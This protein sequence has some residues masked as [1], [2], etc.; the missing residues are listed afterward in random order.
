MSEA[1]M[2]INNKLNAQSSS[3]IPSGMSLGGLP[4]KAG[5]MDDSPTGEGDEPSLVYRAFNVGGSSAALLRTVAS[6]SLKEC[7][8]SSVNCSTI[9]VAGNKPATP[10][11]VSIRYSDIERP[12][13]F[14]HVLLPLADGEVLNAVNGFLSAAGISS[15]ARPQHSN[16]YRCHTVVDCAIVRFDIRLVPVRDTQGVYVEFKRTLGAAESFSKLYKQFKSSACSY[17]GPCSPASPPSLAVEQEQD[18]VDEAEIARA[19]GAM[20]LWIERDPVEAL[21]CVGQFYM[22]RNRHVV[23]SREILSAICRVIEGLQDLSDQCSVM[24]SSVA[25]ACVRQFMVSAREMHSPNDLSVEQVTMAAPGVSRAAMSSDLTARREAVGLLLDLNPRFS[26]DI[27]AR[28]AQIQGFS[29]EDAVW[30]VPSSAMTV[31]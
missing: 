16:L 18:D 13:S 17:S 2:S 3:F 9:S 1:L 10:P 22:A 28:V 5:Q 11:P 30:S 25:M 19:V 20:A 7:T 27:R 26:G 23:D 8:P 31:A 6:V 21:Q 24:T 15:E 29:L 4:A 12:L 14:T